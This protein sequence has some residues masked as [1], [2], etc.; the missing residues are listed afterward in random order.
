MLHTH[1]KEERNKLE[2]VNSDITTIQMGEGLAGQ[3]ATEP[4]R[5]LA[6]TFWQFSE[7]KM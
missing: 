3:N 5:P 4:N 7:M 6:E 1:L 2:D